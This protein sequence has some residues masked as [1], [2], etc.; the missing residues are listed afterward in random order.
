MKTKVW[1]T[2]L[3]GVAG[4][5]AAF[6]Y[7]PWDVSTPAT[8]ER[9]DA[10]PRRLRAGSRCSARW[11]R[12]TATFPRGAARID[13]SPAPSS[14][15][16]PRRAGG[17]GIPSPAARERQNVTVRLPVMPLCNHNISLTASAFPG[18]NIADRSQGH[19]TGPFR[20]RSDRRERRGRCLAGAVA[21]GVASPLA[22]QRS[23]SKSSPAGMGSISF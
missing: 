5:A 14:A 18:S 7:L 13:T 17:G 11:P 10:E 4:L 16:I 23:G 21:I 6:S 22:D 2:A 19:G 8:G 12:R 20:N 3:S 9:P 1:L 15:F